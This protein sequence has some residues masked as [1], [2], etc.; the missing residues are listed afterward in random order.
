MSKLELPLK[1]GEV[2]AWLRELETNLSRV[3][4][5]LKHWAEQYAWGHV[6]HYRSTLENLDYVLDG[7]RSPRIGFEIVRVAA[8][9]NPKKD[10]RWDA[11]LLLKIFPEEM[12][13][14]LY[15]TARK[16]AS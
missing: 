5:K 2:E 1:P 11:R 10:N 14:Q 6:D 7:T 13:T 15:V 9:G 4:A 8:G 16:E 12:R 3:D